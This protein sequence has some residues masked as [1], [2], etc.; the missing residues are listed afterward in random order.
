MKLERIAF[1]VQ[2]I[3]GEGHRQQ[4][5][6]DNERQGLSVSEHVLDIAHSHLLT[7]FYPLF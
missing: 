7:L 6:Q 5:E 2:A 4:V 3:S 1:R